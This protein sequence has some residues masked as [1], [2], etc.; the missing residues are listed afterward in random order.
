MGD[1]HRFQ[2]RLLPYNHTKPIKK[3]LR[4]HVQGKTYQ[5]KALPF[6]LSK[7]P[8]DLFIYLFGA[9]C[10]FYVN[11]VQVISRRVVGR[12]EEISTYSLSGL[13]T[14]NCRTMASNYQ[15]EAMPGT[16]PQPQRWE[17]R[18]LPLCRHGPSKFL[19]SSDLWPNR[20]N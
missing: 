11:T 2:G 15:L 6:G 1:V 9:L 5:F 8:L 18:V 13:C 12:A 7:A 14:V 4:F 3:Y 19:W 16:E 20:S 10:R 17:A